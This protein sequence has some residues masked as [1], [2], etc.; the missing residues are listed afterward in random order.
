ME[1]SITPFEAECMM[2]VYEGYIKDF[3]EDVYTS[4]IP[5]SGL[6]LKLV[7][8]GDNLWKGNP[9]TQEVFSNRLDFIN[10]TYKDY[11][12]LRNILLKSGKDPFVYQDKAMELLRRN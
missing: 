3:L 11:Q 12:E 6:L 8:V 9:K 10:E 4:S 2:E 7:E 1:N 5:D